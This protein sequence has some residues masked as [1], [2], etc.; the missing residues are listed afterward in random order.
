MPAAA[1]ASVVEDIDSRSDRVAGHRLR[2][3]EA[4]R[5][6]ETPAGDWTVKAMKTPWTLESGTPLLDSS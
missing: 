5:E 4:D 1:E 6:R 3:R 2:T